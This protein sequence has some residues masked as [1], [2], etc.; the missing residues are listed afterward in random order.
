MFISKQILKSWSFFYL[1]PI[2][3][4]FSIGTSPLNI[5]TSSSVLG[6]GQESNFKKC[7]CPEELEESR[8]FY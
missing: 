1:L 8:L 5:V 2:A 6:V 3:V 7:V 4:V